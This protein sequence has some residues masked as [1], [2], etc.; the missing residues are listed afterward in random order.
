M[1]ARDRAV[2]AVHDDRHRGLGEQPPDRV[3]HASRGSNPPTCTCT[4]TTR[5]PRSSARANVARDARARGRRSPSAARPACGCAKSATQSLSHAAIPG[6]CGVDQR[7]ERGDAQAAQDGDPL[8]LG[9]PV[10][11]RPGPCRSARARRRRTPTPCAAPARAESACAGPP[12]RRARRPA[13]SPA[14][15]RPSWRDSTTPDRRRGRRVCRSPPRAGGNPSPLATI[16]QSAER[17]SAR[18][19]ARREGA[20]RIA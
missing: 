4:F 9:Q 17:S 5:A 18:P 6:L 11:D 3:E 13:P 2:T 14:A 8:V 16:M 1:R 7:R 10:V 20:P 15:A 19:R 12:G